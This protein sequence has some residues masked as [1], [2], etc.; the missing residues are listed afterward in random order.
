MVCTHTLPF[1]SLI[2]SGDVR[3]RRRAP[4]AHPDDHSMYFCSKDGIVFEEISGRVL[5]SLFAGRNP[6]IPH[7]SHPREDAMSRTQYKII[8]LWCYKEDKISVWETD[9]T[10]YILK[11]YIYIYD[12][13]VIKRNLYVSRSFCC[14]FIWR[15][16]NVKTL[17]YYF[18]SLAMVLCV[19]YQQSQSYE[20]QRIS[21]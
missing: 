5:F 3:L 19:S 18:V 8:A 16:D 2:F 12:K 6:K 15:T 11:I 7:R 4:S 21:V 20:Q 10:F 13:M 1:V 9:L 17:Y 14:Y